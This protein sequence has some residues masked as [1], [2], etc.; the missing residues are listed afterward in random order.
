MLPPHT[1]H[2]HTT[3][4]FP[5]LLPLLLSHPL[6]YRASPAPA[7]AAPASSCHPTFPQAVVAR[8][9]RSLLPSSRLHMRL[10]GGKEGGGRVGRE[11]AEGNS[12][13]AHCSN[14]RPSGGS[15]QARAFC[16]WAVLGGEGRGVSVQLP[17]PSLTY[18]PS[19][20][21]P[22]IHALTF[23]PSHACPHIHALTLMPSHTHPH[24]HA[25]TYM[26]SYTC[27]H[28]H[29]LTC[30]PSHSCPH[31]HALT[32]TH[33]IHALTYHT[34]SPSPLSTVQVRC[35]VSSHPRP[36]SAHTATRG[37]GRGLR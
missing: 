10:V 28:I 37:Q 8:R 21:H 35:W 32:C 4:T 6:H 25:L 31:M 13:G 9:G 27:P 22:H 20:T 2:T 29:A 14:S 18:T 23:M 11:S 26:P 16:G 12:E 19:H 1:P 7:R 5:L 34:R 24:M 36:L 3:L 33:G 17:P 15:G 30:M